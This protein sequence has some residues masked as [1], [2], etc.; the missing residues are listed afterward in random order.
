MTDH[1]PL[2]DQ[3]LDN[4]GR[5]AERL[6]AYLRLLPNAHT[7]GAE[8]AYSEEFRSEDWPRS[9]Y[10]P[11]RDDVAALLAEVRRHRAREAALTSLAERWQKMADHGDTAIGHFE[12]PAAPILDA[13]VGERG[14]AY[15]KAADDVREVLRTGRVPHDL[16]AS[17][18]LAALAAAS[19]AAV[20]SA[21]CASVRPVPAPEAPA[22][23]T[24]A[25]TTA[26]GR[27]GGTAAVETGE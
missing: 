1:T 27:T 23:Q 20:S 15:R 18:E 3:Q 8:I 5:A 7:L 22:P 10:A 24:A 19:V 4:P 25:D 21:A 2:T 6:S 14:R 11:I 9:C 17:A 26:H 12:G 13:E 16:M